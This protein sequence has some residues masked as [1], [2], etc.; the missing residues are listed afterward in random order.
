M[1]YRKFFFLLFSL[2]FISCKAYSSELIEKA[3][4]I[5]DNAY[6]PYSNY[7]VSAAIQTKSGKIYCGVNV[8][9][10]IYTP[11][12]H[13]EGCAIANAITAGDKDFEK[14]VVVTREGVYPCGLC[15][16]M[17]FEFNPNMKIIAVDENGNTIN[18]CYLSELLPIPFGPANL[19]K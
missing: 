13:A 6:C 19:G 18:E 4:Q 10:A 16:Q 5:R 9:N 17:L 2:M 1:Q 7:K 11:T 8:E 3:M 12:I 15:R 14:I